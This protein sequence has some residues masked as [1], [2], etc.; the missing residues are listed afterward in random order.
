MFRFI[1]VIVHVLVPCLVLN[2]GEPSLKIFIIFCEQEFL[3]ERTE[4]MEEEDSFFIFVELGLHV[5]TSQKDDA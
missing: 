2:L 1:V 3:F 5:D 4:I